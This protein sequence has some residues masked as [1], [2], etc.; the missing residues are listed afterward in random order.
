MLISSEAVLCVLCNTYFS[1]KVLPGKRPMEVQVHV[2][3]CVFVCVYMCVCLFVCVCVCV[4]LCVCVRAC[5]R[6]LMCACICVCVCHESR[7]SQVGIP[8]DNLFSL[9]IEKRAQICCLLLCL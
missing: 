2:C 7:R 3:V 4:C 9:K 6:T 1:L 8:P 5:V